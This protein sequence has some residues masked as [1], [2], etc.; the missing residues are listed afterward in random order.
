MWFSTSGLILEDGLHLRS[1]PH[2]PV[3]TADYLPASLSHEDYPNMISPGQL[4]DTIA[5][6]AALIAYNC[7]KNTDRYRRVQGFVEAYP[8]TTAFRQLSRHPKRSDATLEGWDRFGPAQVWVEAN[9]SQRASRLPVSPDGP[10]PT[11]DPEVPPGVDP[12]LFQQF[13]E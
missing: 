6:G 9:K 2:L 4:I 11:K 13:L 10:Q 8:R 3:L 5:V 1:I 12:L 7:L